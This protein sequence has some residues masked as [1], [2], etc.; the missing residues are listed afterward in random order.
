MTK[1]K[2]YFKLKGWLVE[3]Q[4]SQL[5]LAETL[6]TTRNNINKKINGSGS[7]FRLS[8]ARKLVAK[9]HM[10]TSLFFEVDVPLKEQSKRKTVQ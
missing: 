1:R 3:H 9:Y 7:D 10:P 8:E 5:D 2:P 6:G 4:V